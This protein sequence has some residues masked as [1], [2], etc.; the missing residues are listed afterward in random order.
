MKATTPYNLEFQNFIANRLW[1]LVLAV[2]SK[3]VPHTTSAAV[4]LQ[5]IAL[6]EIAEMLLE[7]IATGPSQFDGIHHRDA[8]V[9][10]GEFHDLQRQLGYL[11]FAG[12]S[13]P[14]A[15]SSHPDQPQSRP[16]ARPKAVA[17]VS[18]AVGDSK[19]HRQSALEH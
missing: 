1:A 14:K 4:L 17:Q 10:P 6:G 8:P 11:T 12:I 5:M 19:L 2:P 13:H 9:L 15:G 18:S 16:V 7:S 3:P